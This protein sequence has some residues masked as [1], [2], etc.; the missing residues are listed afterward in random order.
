MD[1]LADAS[2][3]VRDVALA[4]SD[5]GRHR[6]GFVASGDS[7]YGQPGDDPHHS[8]LIQPDGE[9]RDHTT[10]C[11]PDAPCDLRF[12]T[13]GLVGVL[14]SEGEA[15]TRAS[16]W[17]ALGARHTIASTGERMDLRLSLERDGGLL[18][19][20]GDDLT[21]FELD[22]ADEVSLHVSLDLG[23]LAVGALVLWTGDASGAWSGAVLPDA[24]GL[25]CWTGAVPLVEV[26]QRV[27]WLPSGELVI[28]AR[29]EAQPVGAIEV[30]SGA[31]PLVLIAQ[32][33]REASLAPP[34]GRYGGAALAAALQ[35]DLD[36][37]ALAGELLWTY[38]E[39][40]P[41]LF[42]LEPTSASQPQAVTLLG[43]LAPELARGLGLHDD[44][45]T[46]CDV[47]DYPCLAAV[48]VDGSERVEQAWACPLW[49]APLPVAS[50]DTGTASPG[51]GCGCTAGSEGIGPLCWLLLA[52][53]ACRR[54]R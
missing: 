12:G 48:E 31:A 49:L 2:R 39:H 46:R 40:G 3:V 36:A 21:G 50:D 15:L 43:A 28:Y 42:A 4:P 5:H 25:S 14:L 1:G 27:D 7:H 13:T 26:G 19:I 37:S 34:P 51:T 33:G 29:V 16:A 30:P 22:H 45:E 24:Q 44:A 35:Q 6:V 8:F 52:P 32:D 17:R 23:E 54:R 10:S 53:L 9:F 11:A 38:S 18:G 41:F 20:Q 47:A